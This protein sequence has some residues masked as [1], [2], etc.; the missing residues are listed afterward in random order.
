MS[1]NTTSGGC[2]QPERLYTRRG[3]LEA[4][5]LSPRQIRKA[6]RREVEPLWLVVGRKRFIFGSAAI[7]FIVS[8]S[9]LERPSLCEGPSHQLESLVPRPETRRE[10]TQIFGLV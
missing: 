10:R 5:G 1:K 6:G 7:Q 4:S 8:L 2:I 3:F 9:E